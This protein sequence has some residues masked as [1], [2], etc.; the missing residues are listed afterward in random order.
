[1]SAPQ[2]PH[3]TDDQINNWVQQAFPHESSKLVADH[4]WSKVF[5]LQGQEH[6]AFLKVLPPN[7]ADVI[8]KT[9]AI[10][11][12]YAFV[13]PSVIAS[14]ADYQAIILKEHRSVPVGQHSSEHQLH[15]LLTSY[16][17]IQAEAVENISELQHFVPRVDGE[18][19]TQNLLDFLN[20]EIERDTT[21]GAG[22]F[23]DDEKDARRYFMALSDRKELLDNF[24]AES[25]ELPLTLNHCDLHTDNVSEKSDG[26]M[27]IYDWDDAMLGPAGMSLHRL[28]QG[29]SSIAKLMKFHWAVD[30]SIQPLESLLNAYCGALL[31]Q[32]YCDVDVLRK[33][34]PAAVCTGS[35]QSLLSYADYPLEDAEYKKNISEIIRSRI[36]DV[37]HLCDLIALENRD[38]TLYYVDNYY[39][40]HTPW[41]S[42]Y[43]LE[44]YSLRHPNDIDMH[45]RLATL[46]MECGRWECAG[47]S[48]KRVL[49]VDPVDAC[50]YRDLGISLL[51]NGQAAEAIRELETAL[52]IDPMMSEA[53]DF[54]GKAAE[55]VHWTSRAKVPHLAPM[56][57]LTQEEMEANSISSE[58][59]DFS[60][61]MFREY[62]ALVIENAFPREL[63]EQISTIV[64][65]KYDDYF[66]D[67]K[68]KDNLVL[69][70][71]RRIVTLGLE[72]ALNS[73][74]LYGSE[75]LVGMLKNLLDEDYIMGGFN[76]VVSLPGSR[77]QG[78]HKNYS[79]LFKSEENHDTHVTPSFAIAML[80]PLIDMRRE[81]G[82]TSFRKGSHLVPEHMPCETPTQEPLLKMGDCMVLDYRTAH[83]DLGNQTDEVR[84]LL[85]VIHHRTWFRDA[86]N[87]KQQKDVL[88]SDDELEK[89][90]DDLK[91]LFKWV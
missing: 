56:L 84:P 41:R 88:I 23:M 59:L 57:A 22:Y 80:I 7:H 51:K 25:E 1:M 16:A 83:E 21:V 5:R 15:R 11:R 29:V 69:D 60:I 52:Q 50:A 79:P 10:H 19:L 85:C 89:V 90:P 2:V 82:T 72:G 76:A 67:R 13:T 70:D 24:L 65:E 64:F 37:V 78:L 40:N 33:G 39:Q 53:Q 31:D 73:P 6:A 20:S 62:G 68:Y 35:I 30:E 63:I 43:L 38:D 58:K 47:N 87:D 61:N 26:S 48:L 86:L 55:I 18:N 9:K 45:R 28:F 91:K 17:T 8:N 44:Q 81:H 75:I 74:R 49:A 46:E 3:I 34:L 71:K 54:I 36:E 14:N 32:Q 27:L 77:D 4:P 66:E 42:I 12:H